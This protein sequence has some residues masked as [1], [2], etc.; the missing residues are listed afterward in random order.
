MA[1][2]FAVGFFLAAGTDHSVPGSPG[3][4]EPIKVLE[5]PQTGDRARFFREIGFKT[6]RGYDAKRHLAE[7]VAAEA[8]AGF[9]REIS[10]EED[11]PAWAELRARNHA[12]QGITR[13][14][15]E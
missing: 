9:T 2:R 10:P 14:A 6:P 1:S 11:W 7:W 8:K 4:P 5:N 3:V 12:K 15:P 13:A